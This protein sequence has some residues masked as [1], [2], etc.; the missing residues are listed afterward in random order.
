MIAAL[1]IGELSSDPIARTS[2]AGNQ[3]ATANLRVP[4]GDAAQF[5]GLAAFDRTAAEKLLRLKKGDACAATGTLTSNVWTDREGNE[6]SG[7]RMTAAQILS[8]YEATK[9]R[10]AVAEG[11]RSE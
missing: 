5:I 10:K 11:D 3:F 9:R 4:A 8:V 1:L 6:R 2:A 7:W